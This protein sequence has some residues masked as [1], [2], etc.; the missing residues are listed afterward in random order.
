MVGGSIPDRSNTESAGTVG[1]CAAHAHVHAHVHV[2]GAVDAEGI[3][4]VDARARG[5]YST[6]SDWE[7]VQRRKMGRVRYTVRSYK[8]RWSVYR[9]EEAYWRLAGRARGAKV[10]EEEHGHGWLGETLRSLPARCGAE[11][12]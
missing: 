8:E 4:K 5:S 2:A 12:R 11:Q 6:A 3:G 1:I 7:P 9:S 10:E